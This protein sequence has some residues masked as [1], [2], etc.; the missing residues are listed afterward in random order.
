M[1]VFCDDGRVW[2]NRE[3]YMKIISYNIVLIILQQQS[4]QNNYY[5]H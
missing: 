5:N 4:I 2:E 3:E 1:D